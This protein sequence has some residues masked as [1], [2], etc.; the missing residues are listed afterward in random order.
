MLH[1]FTYQTPKQ[2][3]IQ[4]FIAIGEL[5]AKNDFNE[6]KFCDK[7]FQVLDN[8]QYFSVYIFYTFC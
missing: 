2:K 7:N 8:F 3:P 6:I 5:S 1:G 4:V